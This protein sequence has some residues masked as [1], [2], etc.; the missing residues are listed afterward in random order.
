MEEGVR[1]VAILMID[2]EARAVSKALLQYIED[3]LALVLTKLDSTVEAVRGA[4]DTAKSSAEEVNL[5]V[6]EICSVERIRSEIREE[7]EKGTTYAAALKGNVPLSHLNNLARARARARECQIL[8]DR[9]P[10][11]EHNALTELTEQELVA[12][13]NEALEQLE[14][15]TQGTEVTFIGAKILAN[16]GIVYE[17]GNPT[18]ASWVQ[19]NKARFAEKLGGTSVVKERAASVLVE[20]VPVTHA[21][22]AM[23]ELKKIERDSKLPSNT[24]ISTRWIK[25][26]NFYV[27]PLDLSVSVVLGHNWLTCYN[28][29]IDWVLGSI[30]FQTTLPGSPVEPLPA[31]AARASM[32]ETE[33]N[34]SL[35][36]RE[37]CVG[38]EDE[39]GT[40]EVPEVPEA[41]REA[42]G[43]GL[44][45]RGDLWDMWEGTQDGGL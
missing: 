43:G 15:D 31:P 12:K 3:S 39:K 28:P 26:P 5:A 14:G 19:Q 33:P 38:E 29:L 42:H 7:A 37:M 25:L 41:K 36:F 21:L 35:E 11:V 20:Y 44:Q 8:I 18:A 32:A 34:L 17:L 16:G 6:E 22:E 45:W 10:R 40:E 9:D 27:T 1:S 30:M 13:A 2:E 24:L 4:T 23:G